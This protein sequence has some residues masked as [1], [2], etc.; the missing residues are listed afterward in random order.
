MFGFQSIAFLGVS[1]LSE[2]SNLDSGAAQAA[3]H[4]LEQMKEHLS[5]VINFK[6][7]E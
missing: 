2:L 6:K 3:L 1:E 4:S 5:A 7:A